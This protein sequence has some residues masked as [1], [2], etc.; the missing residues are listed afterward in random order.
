MQQ[1]HMDKYFQLNQSTIIK[2]VDKIR[3]LL[4]VKIVIEPKTI[5]VQNLFYK[6]DTITVQFLFLNNWLK[7]KLILVKWFEMILGW[8]LDLGRV[9]LLIMEADCTV[10]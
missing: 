4:A 2:K 10:I 6:V 5:K 7:V 1:A 3:V 9:F 8:I